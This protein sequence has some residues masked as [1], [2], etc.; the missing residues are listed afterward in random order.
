MVA[1]DVQM[2]SSAGRPFTA[3]YALTAVAGAHLGAAAIATTCGPRSVTDGDAA[4][5]VKATSTGAVALL[6]HAVVDA[7]VRATPIALRV[8]I[9]VCDVRSVVCN[10]KA[11]VVVRTP[12]GYRRACC[13]IRNELEGAAGRAD[14]RPHHNARSRRRRR[15]SSKRCRGGGDNGLYK[16]RGRVPRRIEVAAID[17]IDRSS[18]GS[19]L[20]TP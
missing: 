15:P 3:P 2:T 4:S 17:A 18:R 12:I 19:A 14:S 13:I 9:G 6:A 10:A 1:V 8:A 5:F 20:G 16:R 7:A 11:L